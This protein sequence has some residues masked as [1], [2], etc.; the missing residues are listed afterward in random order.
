MPQ[1][2]SEILVDD[3]RVIATKW[4]LPPGSETG[5]HTH[6][7][8]YVVVYLNDR[9]LTVLVEGD[10]VDAPVSKEM[11]T[12]R[13]AGVSHNILNRSAASV[14]FIEIELKKP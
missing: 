8:D 9:V 2:K 7:L 10:E 5:Q 3:M 11:T 1:A 6:A 12:S 13:P 4:T 14:S